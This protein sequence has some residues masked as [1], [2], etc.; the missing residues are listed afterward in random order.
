MMKDLTPYSFILGNPL[1][2]YEGF[3]E[4]FEGPV[5]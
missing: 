5:N 1:L 3:I 2:S 4:R